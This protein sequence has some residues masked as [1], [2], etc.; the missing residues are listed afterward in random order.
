MAVRKVILP[1]VEVFVVL[2]QLRSRNR[3]RQESAEDDGSFYGFHQASRLSLVPPSTLGYWV[4]HGVVTPSRRL[5]A[6]DNQIIAEGFSFADVRYLAVLR[7]LRSRAVP[8]EYAVDVIRH[9]F[10]R[11]GP[12]GPSWKAAIIQGKG[13]EVYAFAKDKWGATLVV[14]GGG[15]Q[16]FFES[17]NTSVIRLIE[18]ASR[19]PDAILVP[20]EYRD[21]VEINPCV[22][23]GMPVV[24]GNRVPT[25]V[26]RAMADNMSSARIAKNVYSF[27]TAKQIDKA[28]AF[29]RY[30]DRGAVRAA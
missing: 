9:L 5:I 7:Y 15:G 14:K 4:Q 20:E 22:A 11:F 13:K 12:P 8:L 27:L 17:L 10:D 23:G 6:A 26:L 30:L 18:E 19:S 29:E 1:H 2:L 24:R 21:S 28:V 16:K 3:R 25:A